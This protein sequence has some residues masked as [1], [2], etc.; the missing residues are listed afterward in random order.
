MI[1]LNSICSA[2][3]SGVIITIQLFVREM[4]LSMGEANGG[5][6]ISGSICFIL[7]KMKKNRGSLHIMTATWRCLDYRA[8]TL[9]G[10]Q[11]IYVD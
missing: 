4:G 2:L 11:G 10:Y 6:V 5:I 8:G 1:L 9:L 7:H 3:R